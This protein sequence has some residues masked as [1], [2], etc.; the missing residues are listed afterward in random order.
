MQ[1][2]DVV[3]EDV[4]V[5]QEKVLLKKFKLGRYKVAVRRDLVTCCR[6]HFNLVYLENCSSLSRYSFLC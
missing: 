1:F 4:F 5:V 6:N 2:V 3:Q